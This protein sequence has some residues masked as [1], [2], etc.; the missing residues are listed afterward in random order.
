MRDT[1]FF[2]EGSTSLL[3]NFVIQSLLAYFWFYTGLTHSFEM[4]CLRRALGSKRHAVRSGPGRSHIAV[5][6]WARRSVLPR[7]FVT[8]A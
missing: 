5:Q 6:A 7:S 4:Q 2:M 1:M 8:L 3:P